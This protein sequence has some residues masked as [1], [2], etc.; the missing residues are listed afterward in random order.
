MSAGFSSND[1]AIWICALACIFVSVAAKILPITFLNA[2]NLPP[3]LRRWLDFVPV[4]VM[5][6]LVGSDIFFYDG[7]LNLSVTNLYLMVSVPT[8]LCAWLTKNYF[9]TIAF[10]LALIIVARALGCN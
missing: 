2:N 9:L 1:L 4:A 8:L 3:F 10:G 7:R 5:A 6:A